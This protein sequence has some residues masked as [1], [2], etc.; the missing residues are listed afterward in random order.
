MTAKGK[1][2]LQGECF[3]KKFLVMCIVS[4]SFRTGRKKTESSSSRGIRKE[5]AVGKVEYRENLLA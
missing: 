4:G 5:M 2:R 3:C 1:H